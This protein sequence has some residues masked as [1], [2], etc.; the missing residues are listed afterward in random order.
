MYVLYVNIILYKCLVIIRAFLS[1][2]CAF[3][4]YHTKLFPKLSIVQFY[5]GMMN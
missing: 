3:V 5:L 2:F 4:S 1:A